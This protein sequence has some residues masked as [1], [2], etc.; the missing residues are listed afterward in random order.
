M[1]KNLSENRKNKQ[2]EGKC[3]SNKVNISLIRI[4]EKENRNV[5]AEINHG[6][7]IDF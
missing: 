2:R 1:K 6:K 5:G 3:E 7:R 4:T